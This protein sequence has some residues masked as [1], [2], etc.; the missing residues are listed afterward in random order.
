M[1]NNKNNYISAYHINLADSGSCASGVCAGVRCHGPGC[2]ALLYGG[3][4]G[5]RGAFARGFVFRFR[6]GWRQIM[7]SAVYEGMSVRGK[8]IFFDSI[9]D[10]QFATMVFPNL[11]I[12]YIS[13]RLRQN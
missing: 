6:K 1:S 9:L 13:L 10:F 2:A 4:R 5:V 3:S 11:S 12:F 7:G 8:I